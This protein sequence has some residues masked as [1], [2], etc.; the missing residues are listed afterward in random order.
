VPKLARQKR[1]KLGERVFPDRP[2]DGRGISHRSRER[3][4]TVAHPDEVAAGVQLASARGRDN[5]LSRLR[6]SKRLLNRS[7]LRAGPLGGGLA[8]AFRRVTDRESAGTACPISRQIS[9]VVSTRVENRSRN[10][11][12][13]RDNGRW[14]RPIRTL[15]I[16]MDVRNDCKYRLASVRRVNFTRR[17]KK[18]YPARRVRIFWNRE[19]LPAAPLVRLA[20][21]R[22]TPTG[23]ATQGTTGEGFATQKVR[24]GHRS[25]HFRDP[26]SNR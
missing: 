21:E 19:V 7:S 14:P 2:P 10:E 8:E 5:S 16:R 6:S 17:V 24:S 22:K 3:T 15:W 1:D 25:G 4:L 9:R 11:F 26:G 20:A 12:E 23:D 13:T 18:S